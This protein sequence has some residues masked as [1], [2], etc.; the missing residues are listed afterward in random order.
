MIWSASAQQNE[1]DFFF[2]DLLRKYIIV[3]GNTFN[4]II[5]Q[6]QLANNVITDIKVPIEFIEKDKTMVR[7]ESDP[8]LDRPFSVLL[9]MMTFEITPP[10]LQYDPSRKLPALNKNV[11]RNPNNKNQFQVQYV[12]VPY[13]IFLNLNIYVKNMEDGSKII[14]QIIPFFQPDFTPQIELIP[15][16]N[17]VRDIPI[18]MMAG[19]SYQDFLTSDLKQRRMLTYTIPFRMRGFFFGPI[20]SR[21]MIKFTNINLR[22]GI[23]T[24][25][26]ITIN[27]V[28]ATG[29]LGSIQVGSNV[30]TYSNNTIIGTGIINEV[31]LANNTSGT[32]QIELLTG[33]LNS[34]IYIGANNAVAPLT[35]SNGFSY[36]IYTSNG[37]FIPTPV[38]AEQ[39]EQQVTET[40]NGQPTPYAN[41]SISWT[42]IDINDDFGF[43]STITSN[44]G[45]S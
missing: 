18:E 7:L 29:N 10:G 40:A 24:N 27:Y 39:I 13:N 38:V 16:M 4:N 31:S 22:A 11:L 15:Q 8:D 44:T 6:R 32:L 17:E 26:Q 14:E 37:D 30:S 19:F 36:G 28:N 33:N 35:I 2:F 25:N 3:F 9:P 21:P 43:S 41:Q 34:T 42:E 23:N 45:I 1:P 5:V 20:R 12:P